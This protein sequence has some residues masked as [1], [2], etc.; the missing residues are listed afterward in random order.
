MDDISGY[1]Y[2]FR[3]A[4]FLGQPSVLAPSMPG[5]ISVS[6]QFMVPDLQIAKIEIERYKNLITRCVDE[7]W[8]SDI[9]NVENRES[10]ARA[11]LVTIA[12]YIEYLQGDHELHQAIENKSR[13]LIERFLGV[14]SYCAGIKIK[15]V[16]IITTRRDG[17]N[18]VATLNAIDK[19]QFP[20]VDFSLPDELSGDETLSDEIFTALFWLRR[21]L[22]ESDPIDTFNALMVCLQILARNWW[23]LHKIEIDMLPTPTILFRDYLIKE[24]GV[25][26]SQVKSAWKKRNGI[27]AHGNKLNIDANDFVGLTELKFEAIGW[28]YKGIN[29]ALGFDPK[30]APR[31]S[32]NLFMTPALMNLD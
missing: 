12:F 25:A 18:L 31:P 32:Q 29:L 6:L 26:P 16:N 3:P 5:K 14:V 28:V 11:T 30:N 13:I 22:A 19:A 10:K 20:K 24:I 15:A 1:N 7:V 21:G 2:T 9:L 23:E 4:R 17:S 8:G 27:A